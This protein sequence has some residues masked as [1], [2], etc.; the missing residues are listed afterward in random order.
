[1]AISSLPPTGRTQRSCNTRRIL[2]CMVKLITLEGKILP[3]EGYLL[4]SSL[5]GQ[6]DFVHQARGLADIVRRSASFHSLH[7]GL[8][9]I[10]SRYEYYRRVRRNL[11]GVAQHLDAAGI[12]HLDICHDHVED[13]AIEFLF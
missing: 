1:M 5:D 10:N 8:I 13:S 7:R 12:R 6:L 9:V 4:Q 2:T 3:A 11:V